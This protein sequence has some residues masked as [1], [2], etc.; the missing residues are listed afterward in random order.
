MLES[1]REFTQSMPE[2]LQWVGVMLISAIPFV[3]SIL[4]SALGVVAG[5][6]VVVAI[7]AAV[8]GNA[9]SM[10]LV[11]QIAHLT[12]SRVRRGASQE[13]KE[14]SP[15][16]QRI[17]RLSERFGVPGVSL[18]G[19]WVLPSQLTAPLL[20]S[21]GA[22]RGWVILWQVAGITLWGVVFGTLAHLGY[23]AVA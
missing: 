19:Q 21:V 23:T 4:G 1:L 14:L 12:R 7:A 9:L 22:S 17:L 5:V 2:A 6:P 18:F 15:R 11:V 20:V 3:E 10:A 16:R 8:V 13:H